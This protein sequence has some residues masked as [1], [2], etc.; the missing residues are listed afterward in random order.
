MPIKNKPKPN[1][2]MTP[3]AFFTPAFFT[4]ANG[5]GR[6][7][8]N[9]RGNFNTGG[10][11]KPKAEEPRPKST[12]LT[13]L[14]N[15]NEGKKAFIRRIQDQGGGEAF[16]Q[17]PSLSAEQV[18]ETQK[19]R[20]QAAQSLGETV[21]PTERI[22]SQANAGETVLEEGQVL[23]SILSGFTA[24]A[25][26]GAAAGGVGALPGAVIGG[27]VFSARE[28]L[29]QIK[30][31][32]KQVTINAYES[33]GRT[34]K[35]Y[36][37]IL[38]MAEAGVDPATIAIYY[39]QNLANAREAERVL[40]YLVQG[41]IGKD[42]YKKAEDELA[43]ARAWLDAEET[44]RLQIIQAINNPTGTQHVYYPITPTTEVP[45]DRIGIGGF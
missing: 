16:Q 44:R 9:A 36:N 8:S 22:Q 10:A 25:A 38:N 26:V 4:P 31:D 11:N 5:S 3:N 40:S 14:R 21:A 34:T 2:N 27:L 30:D 23:G 18:L 20:E 19:Q 24:G 7:P 37:D 42:K 39:N 13:A 33:F 41:E 35:S 43:T 45:S 15:E 6:G 32:Q 28:I 1:Q 17:D 12:P 29:Q